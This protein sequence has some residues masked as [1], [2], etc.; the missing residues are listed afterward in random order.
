[1]PADTGLWAALQSVS[2][3]SA[4]GVPF[5]DVPRIKALLDADPLPMILI[6]PACDHLVAV[7]GGRTLRLDVCPRY[8]FRQRPIL[9][10][11]C[12][13]SSRMRRRRRCRRSPPAPLPGRQEVWA[14]GIERISA[15]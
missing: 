13:A 9:R 3:G 5:P 2:G 15:A 6:Y 11:F 7:T 1:M 4:A 12:A 14:A 8:A 10:L